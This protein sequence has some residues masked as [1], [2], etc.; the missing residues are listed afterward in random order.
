MSQVVKN[1]TLQNN[2]DLIPKTNFNLSDRVTQR[3]SLAMNPF[4]LGPSQPCRMRSS[5]LLKQGMA[6]TAL[7]SNTTPGRKEASIKDGGVYHT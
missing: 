6:S 4:H 2:H 5:L 1:S 3:Q 7:S